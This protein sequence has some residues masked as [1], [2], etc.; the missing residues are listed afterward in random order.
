MWESEVPK[1]SMD[2]AHDVAQAVTFFF[3]GGGGF[4]IFFFGFFLILPLKTDFF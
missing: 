4:A 2:P 3:P 1:V